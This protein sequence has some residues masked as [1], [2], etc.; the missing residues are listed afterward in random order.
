MQALTSAHVC[1]SLVLLMWESSG[2]LISARYTDPS[3][4]AAMSRLGAPFTNASAVT[5]AGM[6]GRMRVWPPAAERGERGSEM[7]RGTAGI[8]GAERVKRSRGDAAQCH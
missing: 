5:P 2:R 4:D 8:V 3:A 6:R 7:G 1:G